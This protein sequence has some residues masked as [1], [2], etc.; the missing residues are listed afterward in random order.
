MISTTRALII[1]D[2]VLS[3]ISFGSRPCKPG[4][5]TISVSRFSPG[6]AE[7]NFTL[8]SSAC[9][10]IMEHPSLMSSVITL[11]P[12]GITAVWRMMPSLNMA[13]SVVPPQYQ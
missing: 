3:D 8:R 2:K 11:P 4:M 13:K 7:P 9:F 10:S 12:K 1:L 6:H 5:A